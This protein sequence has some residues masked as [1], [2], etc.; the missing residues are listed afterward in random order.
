MAVGAVGPGARVVVAVV[1]Q[2][3]RDEAEAR[4]R[5][6]VLQVEGQ[7]AGGRR[8]AVWAEGPQG[9]DVGVAFRRVVDDRVEPD[10][11]VVPGRVLVGR[12]GH[13][14]GVGGADGGV[15]TVGAA[16]RRVRRA[17]VTSRRVAH[18]LFVGAPRGHVRLLVGGILG[19]ELRGDRLHR[20]RI[21]TALTVDLA[22]VGS[23]V[24]VGSPRNDVGE[25][26]AVVGAVGLGVHGRRLTGDLGDVVVE[27]VVPDGVVILQQLALRA[28]RV[29]EVRGR[30]PGTERHVVALV[31]ELDD[32]DVVDLPHGQRSARD[33]RRPVGRRRGGVARARH[34]ARDAESD[35]EKGPGA[36]KTREVRKRLA[37]GGER[38][39]V[40]PSDRIRSAFRRGRRRRCA[41]RRRG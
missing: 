36:R 10:E 20:S 27:A 17:A 33:A 39:P 41:G 26:E 31:L 34:K 35:Q 38:S 3:G 6:G 25:G 28:E 11:G 5:A 4:R 23:L 15:S 9:H 18:V 21:D 22:R 37:H 16:A 14:R 1:A 2:I 13:L 8:C 12:G 32:E 24:R 7:V 19:I 40:H 29:V 30:G